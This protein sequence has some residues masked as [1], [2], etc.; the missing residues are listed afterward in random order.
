M[1]VKFNKS[2]WSAI[3]KSPETE[4]LVSKQFSQAAIESYLAL[5]KGK[6]HLSNRIKEAMMPVRNGFILVYIPLTDFIKK[7]GL[8]IRINLE[9][10]GKIIRHFTG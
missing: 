1:K 8:H 6:H 2:D 4:K 3:Y 9:K 10:E 7:I 5:Q